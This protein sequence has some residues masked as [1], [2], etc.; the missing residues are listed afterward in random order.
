M[1]LHTVFK[2]YVEVCLIR[3]VN[4]HTEGAVTVAVQHLR[5][6]DGDLAIAAALENRGHLFGNAAQI[7]SW[8]AGNVLLQELASVRADVY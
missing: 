4:I 3:Y 8:A 6:S 5:V 7:K 2:V 1:A